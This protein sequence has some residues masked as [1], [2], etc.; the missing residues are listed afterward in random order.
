MSAGAS[1]EFCLALAL[2]SR[3]ATH[4]KAA[5]DQLITDEGEIAQRAICSMR[6]CRNNGN[7]AE[8]T[9][10]NETLEPAR[11]QRTGTRVYFNGL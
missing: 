1:Q 7:V 10:E 4:H 3:E 2:E 11:C 5:C 9:V 6:D 8:F